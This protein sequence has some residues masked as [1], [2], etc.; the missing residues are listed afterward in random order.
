MN[1]VKLIIL[2]ILIYNISAFLWCEEN[3]IVSCYKNTTEIYK[4]CKQE[5]FVIETKKLIFKKEIKRKEITIDCNYIHSF[6]F[7]FDE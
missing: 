2:F 3:K 5:S 4:N 1:T 7:I 6:E